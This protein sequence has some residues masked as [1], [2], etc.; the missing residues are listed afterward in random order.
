MT[1]SYK[2]LATGHNSHTVIAG[3]GLRV[4]TIFGLYEMG[5]SAERI[6]D[7]YN[8]PIAAVFE[9]LAY[10]ADRPD[11]MDAIRQADE[12]VDERLLNELPEHLR[13]VARRNKE[14][15]DRDYQEAVRKAKEGRLG[16]LIP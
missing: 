8:V 12:A 16:T 2:H 7:G 10:A 5:D 6:A 13:Q 3:T 9:A 1:M 11:E 4:Y 14:A 15:D